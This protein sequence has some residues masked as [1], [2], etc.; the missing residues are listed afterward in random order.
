[1]DSKGTNVY[2]ETNNSRYPSTAKKI[3]MASAMLLLVLITIIGSISSVIM[4]YSKYYTN[5]RGELIDE[6]RN[7]LTEQ[8]TKSVLIDYISVSNGYMNEFD[9]SQDYKGRTNFRYMIENEATGEKFGNY[10]DGTAYS[11]FCELSIFDENQK[12]TIQGYL[13]KNRP[14]LRWNEMYNLTDSVINISYTLRYVIPLITIISFVFA[15]F[16]YCRLI[17]AAGHIDGSVTVYACWFDK[18]PF[19][20]ILLVLFIAASIVTSAV[21]DSGIID[22]LNNL[23]YKL[24]N[25]FISLA[26][27]L[28]AA[29][30]F[31]VFVF[32]YI[33]TITLAVRI[34][35]GTLWTNTVAFLC[36][37]AAWKFIKFLWIRFKK[38]CV[39]LSHGIAKAFSTIPVI[40]RTLLIMLFVIFYT[41]LAFFI[42]SISYM[43]SIVKFFFALSWLCIVCAVI[44]FILYSAWAIRLINRSMNEIASGNIGYKTDLSN[45]HFVYR[46]T[47]KYLNSLGY[48]LETAVQAQMKSEHFKTELITN[49]SHDIKT[50]LTSIIN[51]SDLLISEHPDGK[52]GEYADVIYRQSCRL[53]KMT[54]D[55]LE[56]SKAS[57][58]NINV[59]MERIELNQMLS[60]AVGEYEERLIG[61]GIKPVLRLTDDDIFVMADGK[62]LWR[63]FDNLLSNIVKYSL[64]GSRVYIS[65]IAYDGNAVI[66]FRNISRDTLELDTSELAERFV[67]GDSSRHSEGSGLGLGIALSLCELMHGKLELDSDGDL[68]KANVIIPL[69]E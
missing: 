5:Y 36:L 15:I 61:A 31:V 44:V 37:S 49:V 59:E 26:T 1:M 64:E 17:R 13:L 69:S 30:L 28:L 60:Q 29:M 4:L 67:R 40:W 27:I 51:Y 65:L 16:F 12:Y 21:F 47:G 9:C 8:K 6:F 22:L 19:D 38:F 33:A 42:V 52:I 43:P 54:E 34:K 7:T 11:S 46:E 35:L 24:F 18:I 20:L 14:V 23:S 50:P 32:F 66:A 68:F 55:L 57:S 3:I 56:A 45:L 48:G 41:L 53:K 58:G 10:I 2:E 25:N 39:I 63:V 62:L